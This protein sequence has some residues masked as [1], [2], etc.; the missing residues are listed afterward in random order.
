MTDTHTNLTNEQWK[1]KMNMPFITMSLADPVR[2]GNPVFRCSACDHLA[3]VWDVEEDTPRTIRCAVCGI[4]RDEAEVVRAII[5]EGGGAD[6]IWAECKERLNHI[7]TDIRPEPGSEAF[8]ALFE[9]APVF[10]WFRVRE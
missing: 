3:D 1:W 9:G 10:V 7:P 2:R 4:V 5:A 8:R 6:S